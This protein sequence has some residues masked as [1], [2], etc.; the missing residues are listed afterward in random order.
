MSG[1]EQHPR[2]VNRAD[3]ARSGFLINAIAEQLQ[4][5]VPLFGYS[6]E[7]VANGAVVARLASTLVSRLMM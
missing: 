1:N 7:L 2:H 5:Q 3:K 6:E 4:A